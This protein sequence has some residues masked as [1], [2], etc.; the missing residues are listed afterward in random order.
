[1]MKRMMR[2]IS[3]EE[4][5][6]KRKK[7][8]RVSKWRESQSYTRQNKHGFWMAGSHIY[9]LCE[10]FVFMFWSNS[11]KIFQVSRFST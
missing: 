9:L 6:K 5:F 3:E 10:Y 11:V 8:K 1:M 2:R 7:L 4:V